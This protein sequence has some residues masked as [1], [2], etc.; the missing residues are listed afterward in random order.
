MLSVSY[1]SDT[2]I[3]MFIAVQLM[4]AESWKSLVCPSTDFLK[5][6]LCTM[7][8][9]SIVRKNESCVGKWVHLKNIMLSEIKQYTSLNVSDFL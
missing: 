4:I 8:Y 3:P 5:V 7:G 9:Y 6:Y 1:Y 2:Y